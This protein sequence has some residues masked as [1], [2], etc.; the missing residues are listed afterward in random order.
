MKTLKSLLALLLVALV[1]PL[2]ASASTAETTF[3]KWFLSTDTGDATGPGATYLAFGGTVSFSGS[4]PVI[5][6]ASVTADNAADRFYLMS[7]NGD[8]TTTD[9][10]YNAGGK[11]LPVTATTSFQ[12][13]TP[14]AGSWIAIQNDSTKKFEINRV[15]SIT[16]G[17]SLNLVRNTANTY[18]SGT[19]VKELTVL[20]SIPVGNA[21]V[22]LGQGIA[23]QVGEV[24]GWYVDGTSA[25]R[26]NAVSGS[27]K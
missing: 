13:D 19:K 10:A 5:E 11:I 3:T 20:Y 27:Y 6:F 8:S 14:G 17:A 4:T 25:C 1:L 22:T 7:E 12:A 15:S 26:I 2:A 23:G 24:L 21:T 18:A 9:E 16:A